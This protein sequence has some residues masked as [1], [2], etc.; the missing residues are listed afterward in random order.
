MARA[1]KQATGAGVGKPGDAV[2]A[3]S[4]FAAKMQTIIRYLR[5]DVDR[6]V[7]DRNL[8]FDLV[9][10]AAVPEPAWLQGRLYLSPSGWLL[11]SV[12]NAFVRGV[13]SAMSEPGA[14]LPLVDSALSAHISVMRPDEIEGIGGPEKV[15]E[16]GKAFQYSPRNFVQLDPAGWPEMSRVWMVQVNSPD[17]QKLRRS[18]GLSGLPNNDKYDFHITCAVRRRGVLGH[19]DL[20]KVGD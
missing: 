3:G 18:Y 2:I 16:R 9:K 15:T 14:Q 12:P 20:S 7:R 1:G 11:L 5:R 10:A 13:F 8:G 19:N 4:D 17:L 6:A